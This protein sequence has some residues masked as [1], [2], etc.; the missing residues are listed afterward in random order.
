MKLISTFHPASSVV[1]CIKCTLI[2]GIDQEHLVVAKP[3]KL[4]VFALQ[5]DGLRFETSIHIWGRILHIRE[6]TIQ[7]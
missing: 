3:D 7:V 6:I 4:E 1:D 5:P 2:S